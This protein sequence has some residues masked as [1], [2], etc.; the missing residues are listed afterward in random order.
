MHA[1]VRFAHIAASN[2]FATSEIYSHVQEALGLPPSAY[3]LR[4]LRYDLWKLRAKGLVEKVPHS[5]RYRLPA[6]GYRLCLVYLKLFEKIY[7]PLTA[8]RLAPFDGDRALPAER[9]AQ[10]DRLY[11]RVVTALDQLVEAVGLKAA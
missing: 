10:R 9:I 2:T 7:A 11:Q 1:L 8:G 3:K 5:H 6:V 4:S